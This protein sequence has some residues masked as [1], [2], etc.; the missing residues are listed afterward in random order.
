MI[1]YVLDSGTGLI[2]NRLVVLMTGGNRKAI[3][4]FDEFTYSRGLK[5]FHDFI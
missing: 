2:W 5:H 4:V 1:V 3:M